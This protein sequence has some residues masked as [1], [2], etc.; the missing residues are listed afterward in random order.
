[1]TK[2]ISNKNLSLA[3]AKKNDEFFTREPDVT[4]EVI[5]YQDYYKGKV[6]LC[7]CDD[8]TSEFYHIL[9]QVYD[10]F[11]IKKLIA[12]SFGPSAYKLEYENG[13]EHKTMLEGNGD[14]SSDECIE[15]LKECDIVITNPPFSLFRKFLSLIIAYDKKFLAI[16]NMNA[17]TYK[18]VF[19]LIKDNKVWLGLNTPKVFSV[20][21]D[22]TSKN[23]FIE[24][25]KNYAKFGN[26]CW[27]TNLPNKKRKEGVLLYQKYT[28]EKYPKYDNYDA[29]NVDKVVDIPMDY[30]GVIGV[31]ISFLSLYSPEQFEIIDINPHFFSLTDQG[32][33]KIKQLTLKNAN[34]KDPYARILIKR[35]KE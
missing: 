31:P 5:K 19:K 32:L 17:I 10:L 26:I 3:R 18:D 35:R 33:P 20:K 24:Y 27:F 34:K 16:G 7:N 30:Y 25:G 22:Y 1:M 23:T 21:E 14:F 9:K 13:L 8:A 4:A 15:L 11:E 6:I 28:P 29:I 2:K 12:T